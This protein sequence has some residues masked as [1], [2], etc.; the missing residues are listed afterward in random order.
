M[1]EKSGALSKTRLKKE[2]QV[3]G[4]VWTIVEGGRRR[5]PN[6]SREE[7]Y[8]KLRESRMID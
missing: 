2:A 4:R 3:G 1:E 5:I 7:D 8:D 6:N